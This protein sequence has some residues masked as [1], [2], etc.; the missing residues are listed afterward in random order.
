MVRY[1]TVLVDEQMT[2][3]MIGRLTRDAHLM[4]LTG[5]SYPM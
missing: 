3:A 4:V 5:E 2:A 1:R